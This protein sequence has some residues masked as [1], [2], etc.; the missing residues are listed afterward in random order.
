MAANESERQTLERYQL[1][2]SQL[3]LSERRIEQ[4]NERIRELRLEEPNS[5]E[6]KDL[7]QERK[8]LQTEITNADRQLF[9]MERMAPMRR[10]ASEQRKKAENDLQKAKE[11]MQRY[12]QGL[13]QREMIGRVERTSR[14][15]A[16]WLT[17]PAGKSSQYVP[18]ALRRNFCL[19]TFCL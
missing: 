12:R 19:L 1:M 16:K 10:I 4:I 3:D 14:R 5:Q 8:Q 2:T 15:L 9:N 7:L 18:E 6:E 13:L 11:H 17:A